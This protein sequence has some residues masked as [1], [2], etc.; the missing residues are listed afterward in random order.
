MG[1]CRPAVFGLGLRDAIGCLNLEFFVLEVAGRAY[2]A[3]LVVLSRERGS[4]QNPWK[5][6][7]VYIYMYIYI[8]IHVYTHFVH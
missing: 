8:H 3:D 6:L 5:G 4:L 7:Y 1:I 2:N